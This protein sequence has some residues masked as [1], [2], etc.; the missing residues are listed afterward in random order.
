MLETLSPAL[1][2][3]VEVEVQTYDLSRERSGEL[4]DLIAELLELIGQKESLEEIA[5]RYDSKFLGS[6]TV[7]LLRPVLTLS[8]QAYAAGV[9]VG[10]NPE[11][12]REVQARMGEMMT[13]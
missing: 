3:A 1:Q 12:E 7:S 11:R 6:R 2:Q 10:H 9:T 13:E 8:Y 4:C 5:A